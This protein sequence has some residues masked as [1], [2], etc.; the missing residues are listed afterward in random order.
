MSRFKID[1]MFFKDKD[2]DT[3]VAGTLSATLLYDSRD[4]A[5][6]IEIQTINSTDPI[7]S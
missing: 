1:R 5:G 6:Q 2:R 4:G 7:D 3:C